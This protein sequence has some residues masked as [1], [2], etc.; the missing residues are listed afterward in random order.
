[1]KL[2]QRRLNFVVLPEI[3]AERNDIGCLRRPLNFEHIFIPL[4]LIMHVIKLDVCIELE[5]ESEN[6]NELIAVRDAKMGS[7]IILCFLISF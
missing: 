4:Q 6:E 7:I 1:M 3:D 2:G 5:K